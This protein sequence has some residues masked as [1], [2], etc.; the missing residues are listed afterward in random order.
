MVTSQS[1]V[2]SPAAISTGLEYQLH[3][4]SRARVRPRV[5][6]IVEELDGQPAALVDEEV[7]ELLFDVQLRLRDGLLVLVGLMQSFQVF[8]ARL[9]GFRGES[10]RDRQDLCRIVSPPPRGPFSRKDTGGCQDE[11]PITQPQVDIKEEF[12][13]LFVYKGRGLTVQLPHYVVYAGADS[14]SGR[15]VKLVPKAGADRNWTPYKPA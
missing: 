8:P 4:P 3:H 14:G 2:R 6:G 13:D 10:V 12:P 1:F 7:R 15:M 9:L 5:H 11:Q